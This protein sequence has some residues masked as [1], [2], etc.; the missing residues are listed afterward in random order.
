MNREIF[1]QALTSQTLALQPLG[2]LIRRSLD[3]DREAFGQI[4]RRYQGLVSGVTFG[5]TGDLQQSEDLAQETFVAA[6]QNQQE[7][8]D[9]AKLPAWLCGIARNLSRNWLRRTENERRTR[10]AASLEDM[11]DEL[12]DFTMHRH[13]AA[14]L[15]REEQAALLW[16]T[17]A[18]IP[19]LYREPLVM[20]YRQN[21]LSQSWRQINFN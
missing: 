15:E 21:Q 13:P 1:D 6:W 20:F 8:R 9:P 14:R 17:L 16:A 2:E 18:Q 7:L 10:S 19:E 5:M 4:V 12:P 11:P 3:G